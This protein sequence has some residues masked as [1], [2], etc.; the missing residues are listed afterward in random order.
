MDIIVP[1]VWE[2]FT[3]PNFPDFDSFLFRCNEIYVYKVYLTFPVIRTV[4]SVLCS[5]FHAVSTYD[6]PVPDK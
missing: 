6:T 2:D 5:F 3:I 4:I 1:G